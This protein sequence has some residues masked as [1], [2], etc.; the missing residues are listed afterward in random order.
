MP[1]SSKYLSPCELLLSKTERLCS[2]LNEKIKKVVGVKWVMIGS[3]SWLKKN[4]DIR[5]RLQ[6]RLNISVAGKWKELNAVS[7]SQAS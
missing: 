3:Y 6:W 5:R 7:E 2:P 1:M 4:K